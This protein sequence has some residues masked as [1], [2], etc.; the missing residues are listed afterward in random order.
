[1]PVPCEWNERFPLRT[2]TSALL[3][4]FSAKLEIP[5]KDWGSGQTGSRSPLCSPLTETHCCL[6]LHSATP[7]C[8]QLPWQRGVK[9]RGCCISDTLNRVRNCYANP[10]WWPL[11]TLFFP[12]AG[13]LIKYVLPQL[14][15]PGPDLLLLVLLMS[16]VPYLGRAAH[17]AR[18][19]L[20]LTSLA[21]LLDRKQSSSGNSSS[22]VSSCSIHELYVKSVNGALSFWNR[23]LI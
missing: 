3:P 17:S 20:S 8:W 5:G 1:M 21:F 7:P 23:I 18:S 15:P 10:I 4:P 16:T 2:H 19:F 9:R 13:F 14:L 12:C 11:C 22:S 6:K